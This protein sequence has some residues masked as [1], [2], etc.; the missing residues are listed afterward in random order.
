MEIDIDPFYGIPD[1]YATENEPDPLVYACYAHQRLGWRWF[2]IEYDG[3]RTFFG[4]V[5]GFEI[6]LGYFDRLELEAA[7]AKLDS[8]REPMALSAVRKGLGLGRGPS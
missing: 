7:G 2:V 4:L 8:H 1:L 5:A 3:S 6:E